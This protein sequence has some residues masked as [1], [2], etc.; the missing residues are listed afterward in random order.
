MPDATLNSDFDR[1]V[2]SWLAGYTVVDIERKLILRTLARHRGSR[3]RAAQD[4]KISVGNLRNKI[5]VQII[6]SCGASVL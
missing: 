5:S 2:D 4:L 6:G 1:L 3:T